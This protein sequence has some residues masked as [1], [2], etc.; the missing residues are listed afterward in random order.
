MKPNPHPVESQLGKVW[1]LWEDFNRGGKD[2]ASLAG[3]ESLRRE[4]ARLEGSI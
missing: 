3:N 4:D 2:A 1:L